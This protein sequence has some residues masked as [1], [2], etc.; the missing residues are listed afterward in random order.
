MNVFIEPGAVVN[1]AVAGVDLIWQSLVEG[2]IPRA[3]LPCPAYVGWPWP[4]VYL[5]P[6][7]GAPELGVDRK[8]LRTMEKQAKLVLYGACLTVDAA[9]RFHDK[10]VNATRR[11]L[12]LALPTVDEAVP[13]WS[14]LETLHQESAQ[15]A[16]PSEL[17][18][19]E[20]LLREVPAFFGLS[21]LN[22][23][24]C[25]HISA[26]FGLMGAMA[27]HSP[28]ADAAFQAL[29]DALESIRNGENHLALVGAVSP[30]VNPQLLLQ[31]DHRGWDRHATRVPAEAAAFVTVDSKPGPFQVSGYA[32]GFIA[33]PESSAK[34]RAS[35]LQQALSRAGLNAADLDWY[36]AGDDDPAEQQALLDTGIDA[37]LPQLF[38]DAYLGYA[39]CAGPLVNLNIALAGLQ[40]QTL[41][42]GDSRHSLQ[43]QPRPL[44]HV[45]LSACGPEGQYLIIIISRE[46]V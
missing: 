9:D 40:R 36:V 18:S 6:E 28:F 4:S 32:R 23:N 8:I 13:P 24:A 41:L 17:D 34:V 46:A 31:Y 22:S 44:R 45:A 21:T 2:N 38:V 39:G 43:V 5:A 29:I 25:A 1:S 19:G 42:T 33:T 10:Q 12:Y 26:R 15:P 3:P 7:P 30:K 37:Q 20:F 27:A 16:Q 14:L 35:L 11:G